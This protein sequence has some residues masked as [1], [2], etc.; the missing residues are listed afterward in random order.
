MSAGGLSADRTLR[1]WRLLDGPSFTDAPDPV[2]AVLPGDVAL[3]VRLQPML[4]ALLARRNIA[5]PEAIARFLD[6][7]D[8]T[9]HDPMLLPDAAGLIARLKEAGEAG[10]PVLVV[11][12]FDADGL[13]GAAIMIRA[14]RE[15][16]AIAEGYIPQRAADGHGIPVGALAAAQEDGVELLLAVDC[17]TGDVERV[18]EAHAAGIA[19]GIIDHHAVPARPAPADWLVNPHRADSTY[20]FPH[21]AGSGLA[22]KIA[23]GLLVDH[24]ERRRILGELSVL[25]MIGGIADMVPVADE[26]RT[27]VRSALRVLNTP[28]AAPAGITALLARA[29]AEGPHRVDV[30]GFT[31]SPRINAAG[32]IGDARPALD[33]LTAESGAEAAAYAE[34]LEEANVQRKEI[35]RDALAEARGL[36]GLDGASFD[37]E[38]AFIA[39][40]LVA[41]RGPWSPG[42][43][44][45]VAGRLVEEFGRPVLVGHETALGEDPG[46]PSEVRCSIRAPKGYSV[47]RA[48]AASG[49]SLLRHGGHDGA[50]GC[51][52]HAGDWNAVLLAISAQFAAQSTVQAPELVVD[53]EPPAGSRT[54]ADLALLVDA[55]APTGIGNPDPLFLL[56]N[57]TLA[58]VRLVGDGRHARVSVRVDGQTAEGI[59][60]GRPDAEQLT[61][62]LVDLVVRISQRT[63]R[64]SAKVEIQV[65]DLRPA[66][67]AP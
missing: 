23:Q 58:G 52:F 29:A 11:G 10:E 1:N 41:I 59:A 22:F 19:V 55:L 27:I 65:V 64:G 30:V 61:G 60:F 67:V 31:L 51:S 6:V 63:Y 54:L 42:V 26:F 53:L 15:A 28:G 16:G 24:P 3:P 9:L 38:R 37:Q 36:L 39:D 33:L 45:L 25:A 21:L 43:L 20:P 62:G 13:T 50:G 49:A 47:A 40:G 14:L 35:M 8:R 44:G 66:I 7:R 32:R 57:V 48:L 12:D 4:L 5:H 18:E 56:R 34:Q 17:G 2:H 46:A